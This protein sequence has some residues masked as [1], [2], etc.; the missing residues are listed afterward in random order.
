MKKLAKSNSFIYDYFI[1]Q[2][3]SDDSIFGPKKVY[4]IGVDV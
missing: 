4:D 1:H 3:C 2:Y